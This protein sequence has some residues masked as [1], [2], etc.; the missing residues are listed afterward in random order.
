MIKNLERTPFETEIRDTEQVIPDD[1]RRA[2]ETGHE[3]SYGDYG[4][5]SKT[6][7][8]THNHKIY[9]F[10]ETNEAGIYGWAMDIT[11]ED[12]KYEDTKNIENDDEIEYLEKIFKQDIP[13]DLRRALNEAPE[14][15]YENYGEKKIISTKHNGKVYK[16]HHDNGDHADWFMEITDEDGYQLHFADI[17]EESDAEFLEKLFERLT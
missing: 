3:L 8:V 10:Y 11:G 1:L 17:R 16:F 12:G 5:E 13:D 15:S 9:K 7:S 2:L 4:E 6:I 14:V